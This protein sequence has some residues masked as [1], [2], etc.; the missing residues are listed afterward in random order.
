MK[1]IF[2]T[3]I[4]AIMLAGVLYWVKCAST[5]FLYKDRVWYYVDQQT[6]VNYLVVDNKAVTPRL[7]QSGELYITR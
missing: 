4:L 1:G 2:T 5:P 3:I 7:T 6:G